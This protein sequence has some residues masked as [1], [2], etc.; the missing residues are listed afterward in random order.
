MYYFSTSIKAFAA[1]F[2]LAS[3]TSVPVSSLLA[4]NRIDFETTR[5]ADLRVALEL[6]D[7]IQPK[8]RGVMLDVDVGLGNSHEKIVFRLVPADS[9]SEPKGLISASTSGREIHTF[10]LT[11]KDVETLEATR[12]RILTGK[13]K[14]Q[15]GSL[16]FGVAAREFCQVST[17]PKDGI[18]A[19]TFIAT[20][21]TG[22]Y[23]AVVK[24]YDLKSDRTVANSLATLEKCS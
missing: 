3:C 19:S 7:S 21:E 24:D 13:Q 11:A 6:P 16:G 14:G 23:I 9:S 12:Q 4:L 1:A 2:L 22:G 10:K 15:S 17:M 18:F 8:A 20:S 5:L